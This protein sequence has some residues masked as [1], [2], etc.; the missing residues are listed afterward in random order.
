MIG[1]LQWLVQCT[2]PDLAFAVS[3]LSQFLEN[4]LKIHYQAVIHVLHYLSNTQHYALTLGSNDLNIAPDTIVGFTDADWGGSQKCKSSSGSLV[5]FYGSV[6][7]RSHLQSCSTLSSAESEY[8]ALTECSQDTLW[9]S[10]LLQEILQIKP[11]IKIYTDSQSSIAI[12]S[13]DIYHHGTRHMDFRY[14]FIRDHVRAKTIELT[15]INTS[16]LP[17]DAL[18]K[19]LTGSKIAKHSKIMLGSES[20][21]QKM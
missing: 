21:H 5:Y 18:T 14:H 10:N 17:A 11:N 9:L 4:P 2:R 19:N 12:A 15:Y 6:G 8:V 16:K 13:N 20:V 3:S 1:L 7:W